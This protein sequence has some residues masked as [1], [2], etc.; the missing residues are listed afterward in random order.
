MTNNIN[1]SKFDNYQCIYFKGKLVKGGARTNSRLSLIDWTKFEGKTVL[2]LGCSDGMMSIAA[3]KHGAS[4]VLGVERAECIHGAEE[5]ARVEGL[6][7]EFWQMDIESKEFQDKCPKFDIVFFCAMLNHMKD[8]AKILEFI[9]LHTR[10]VL[11]YETNFENKPEPHLNALKTYTSFLSYHRLGTSKTSKNIPNAYHL[12]KCVHDIR[13]HEQAVEH[14][15]IQ[16][17]PVDKIKIT[18]KLEQMPPIKFKPEKIKVEALMENIKRNGLRHP[19]LV[20]ARKDG[21]WHIQEGGHRL[22]AVEKLGWKT[23]ATRVVPMD[24]RVKIRAGEP[25]T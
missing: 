14:L 22:L 4:K 7:I 10:E 17:L 21:C 19:L 9:D 6:D 16:L 11:Y 2:D 18:Q 15:P 1:L 5:L 25:I 23:V 12:F 24:F 13:H 3:K 20:S 8:K